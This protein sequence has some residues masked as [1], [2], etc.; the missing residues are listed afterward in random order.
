MSR[1]K[2]DF[3]ELQLSEAG[4]A[5]AGKGGVLQIATA[6]LVYKF[7]AGSTTRVL[8]SEWSRVLSR[9][10]YQGQP[11]FEV[12]PA[13]APAQETTIAAEPAD[14]ESAKAAKKGSK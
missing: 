3:V 11:I 8:T 10:M 1:Q 4:L 2:T 13:A 6:R 12:A 9:E 14:P 5:M 7:T